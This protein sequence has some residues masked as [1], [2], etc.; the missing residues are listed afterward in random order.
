MSSAFKTSFRVSWTDTDAAQVVHFPNYFK[1]FEKA[2]E[3][4]Y[5]CLGLDVNDIAER[6]IWLPR[7]EVFC[8]FKKSAR[9]NDLLEVELG[10]ED[11]KEKSIRYN[12]RVFNKESAVL[13]ANGYVTVVAA[14]RQTGKATQIPKEIMEKLK[15]YAND[16]RENHSED[17]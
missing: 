16:H 10:I 13:L 4:L 8:Q 9:F 11:I 14:N 12:F 1:F 15:P 5:R 6:G 17:F 3:E 7:V 2:E